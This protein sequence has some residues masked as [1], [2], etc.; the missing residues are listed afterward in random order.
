MPEAS[1]GKYLGNSGEHYIFDNN[2]VRAIP[3]ADLMEIET[4]PGRLSRQQRMDWYYGEIYS[5]PGVE[6]EEAVAVK[7]NDQFLKAVIK[8][9]Q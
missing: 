9:E 4:V 8:K 7:I 1:D 3:R 5:L 2:T 6:E